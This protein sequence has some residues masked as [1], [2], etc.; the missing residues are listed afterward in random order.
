MLI[1][2]IGAALSSGVVNI[3]KESELPIRRG[4]RARNPP[5]PT[6]PPTTHGTGLM[7]KLIEKSNLQ[8]IILGC[9]RTAAE[10]RP[11]V[12]TTGV[13]GQDMD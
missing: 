13:E 8:E 9:T 11:Q 3:H 6:T 10:R 7:S 4:A 5:R 2:H 12:T 1:L